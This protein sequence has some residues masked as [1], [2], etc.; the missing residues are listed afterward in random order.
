MNA[1]TGPTSAE[2][3]ICTIYVTLK[4]LLKDGNLYGVPIFHA[5]P[6]EKNKERVTS[7]LPT[8]RIY[9]LR[10]VDHMV[11]LLD[12]DESINYA[13]KVLR[14]RADSIHPRLHLLGHIHKAHSI[15]KK[16]HTLYSNGAIMN[17]SYEQLNRPLVLEVSNVKDFAAIQ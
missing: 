3:R 11:Y 16:C 4:Y 2:T 5:R 10:I 1:C 9:L 6:H 13:S 17:D 8:I 14:E 12:L 7:K 15:Q